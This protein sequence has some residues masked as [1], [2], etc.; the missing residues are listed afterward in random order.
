MAEPVLKSLTYEAIQTIEERDGLRYE[1]WGDE[2]V[3]MTGGTSAHNLIALGLNR[4]L[5]G[6]VALPCVA[7][8]T[9]MAVKLQ[10]DAYSDKAYPDGMVV[11]D[12]L[13]GYYQTSPVI[14][15]EVLSESS[16]KRDRG[17]KWRAYT[18]LPS[19][20]VYLII[21]QTSVHVEVYRRANQWQREDYLGVDAVIELP[22][23]KL[24][25]ALADIYAKVLALNLL[26][27][28]KG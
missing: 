17:D 9:D 22:Q 18:T 2:L 4:V 23:P 15:A 6:Q 21:S 3:A 27:L 5:D 25:L 26:G 16:V 11:R 14:L 13:P 1:R 12:P 19:A 7:Y 8:V 24:S 28:E 10:S 20:E